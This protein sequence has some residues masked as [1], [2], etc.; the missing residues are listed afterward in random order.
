MTNGL[1]ATESTKA[2]RRLILTHGID[3]LVLLL[4]EIASD[5]GEGHV[6]KGQVLKPCPVWLAIAAQLSE[7]SENIDE[8]LRGKHE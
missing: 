5:F 6:D 4:T 3:G 2:I 1:D 7:C 8:F